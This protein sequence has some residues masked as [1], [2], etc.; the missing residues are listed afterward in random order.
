MPEAAVSRNTRKISVERSHT[1]SA[2]RVGKRV[3]K[4]RIVRKLGAGAFATVYEAYDTIAGIR[5]ALKVPF[6][7]FNS[8]E[9]LKDFR[10]E[11]RLTAGLDHPHVLPVKDASVVDGAFIIAYPLGSGTLADRLTRRLS[12]RTALRFAQQM[13]DAVAFA[14][15]RRIMHCDVKP[16]NFIVFEGDDLRLADF[17]IARVAQRTLQGAGE[18]TVGYIAPEQA[19]GK[20]SFR[21]D[22]FALGLIIYRMLSG[23]L[24]EWPY[25]WP[26]VGYERAR[27]VAHPELLALLQRAIEVDHRKRFADAD[28]M[29][30][31]YRRIR[32]AVLRFATQKG[33]GRKKKKVTKSRT[34]RDWRLVRLVEFVKAFRK[35]FDLRGKCHR[36]EGPVAESMHYCPWC[37]AKRRVSLEETR[38]PRN[39]PRCKRGM[40]ADW[41]FCA[42]CF[43]PAV[44]PGA[45]FR[46]PD[47]RY[48]GRCANA[49]CPTGFLMP[50]M[51]Y[52]PWCRRKVRNKWKI[53]G[54]PNRCRSCG[55]GI[56]KEY[57]DCC[58][59]CGRSTTD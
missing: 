46:Y 5:V 22:V 28:R 36:C 26:P 56:V 50:F 54:S 45:E 32:P 57:W 51:R 3:G 17:G 42:H 47:V 12:T 33:N 14:H 41:R 59:W 8:K 53:E 58:A 37:R 55:W 29:L 23:R 38:L 49:A 34:R 27:R 24:P 40:K 35:T 2:I 18:G 10:K 13:L 4:Y 20:P 21:S 6:A 44:N 30:A 48:T 16:E 25:G 52:C 11:V 19:M 1:N 39:C 31:A 15:R 7:P 43:G 9:S